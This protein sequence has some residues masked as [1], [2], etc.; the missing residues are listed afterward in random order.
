M[1][2]IDVAKALATLVTTDD[3]F[4]SSIGAIKD[5]WW[6]SR[7]GPVDN[8]FHPSILGSVSD[9]A[10]GLAI[11]LPHRRVVALETDGSVLMNAG[12][13]CTL[14]HERQPN[15]TVIVLDNGVYESI[16]APPTLT[17]FNTDLAK[18]ADAAGCPDTATAADVEAFTRTADRMLNDGRLGYLVA[19]IQPG[20]YP[21]P[22]EKRKSTDG[23]EDKYRF[24]RHV[25][26]L[27]GIRIHW[28]AP[29]QI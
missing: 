1:F 6:N 23:I 17:S 15:L 18:M 24:M 19:K 20:T 26:K 29:P 3:L 2:R 21:W 9:M 11:A 10:L 12:A 25:E 16:G 14:G 4:I 28:G 8:T 22:R 13:M 5:D 7:P 27:E